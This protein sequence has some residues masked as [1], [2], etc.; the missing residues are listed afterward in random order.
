VAVIYFLIGFPI[1]A[2]S[3]ALERKLHGAR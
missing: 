1:S 2:L 3:R